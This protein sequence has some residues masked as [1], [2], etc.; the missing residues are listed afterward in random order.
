MAGVEEHPYDFLSPSPMFQGAFDWQQ[1][2]E[3]RSENRDLLAHASH[4]WWQRRDA[5]FGKICIGSDVWIGE[6]AL[7]RRSVNI[8]HGAVI[9]SR[10][11]VT[12]DVPPYAIV[13]GTPAHILR[14]RFEPEVIEALLRLNWWNYGLSALG[15]VDMSN[16]HQ[17][18]DRIEANIASGRAQLY[19]GPIAQIDAKG[20]VNLLH[21]DRATGASSFGT[22]DSCRLMPEAGRVAQ[23]CPFA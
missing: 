3:F 6:G 9:A 7:I 22:A 10:A 8:G 4:I 17:A 15:G 20:E 13:G 2:D 1:A 5:Q 16:V 14:Y 23:V 12:K 18:I 19:E 21:Y 11:V